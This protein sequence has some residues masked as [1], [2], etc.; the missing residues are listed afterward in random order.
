MTLGIIVTLEPQVQGP[1]LS[2][3]PEVQ[4][5]RAWLLKLA[6]LRPALALSLASCALLNKFWTF[7]APVSLAYKVA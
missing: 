5:L 2:W 4:W 7:L 6:R 1:V 3:K